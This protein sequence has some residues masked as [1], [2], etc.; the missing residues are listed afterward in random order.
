LRAL[1]ENL[2]GQWVKSLAFEREKLQIG[3]D[4]VPA[5]W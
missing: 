2:E 1:P 3:K 5:W 4:A